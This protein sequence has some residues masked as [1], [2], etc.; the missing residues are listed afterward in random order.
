VPV[1][2]PPLSLSSRS[3]LPYISLIILHFF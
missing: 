2:C 3:S 1:S